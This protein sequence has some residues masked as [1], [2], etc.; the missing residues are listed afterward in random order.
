MSYRFVWSQLPGPLTRSAPP[1]APHAPSCATVAPPAAPQTPAP[2]NSPPA[3]PSRT[4]PGIPPA[5]PR[6]RSAPAEPAGST[7]APAAT[8]AT[9]RQP[10]TND[11]IISSYRPSVPAGPYRHSAV[12]MELLFFTIRI[13][14]VIS[15]RHRGRA[16]VDEIAALGHAERQHRYRHVGQSNVA[17]SAA[18]AYA[19]ARIV[20]VLNSL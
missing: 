16:R 6:R 10:C 3:V 11:W 7:S 19:D 8:R 1:P 2:A 18:A 15:P 4:A 17:E 13:R 5:S 9:L 12:E 14:F 20:G